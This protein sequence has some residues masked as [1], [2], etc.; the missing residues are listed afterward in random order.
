MPTRIL[1]RMTPARRNKVLVYSYTVRTYHRLFQPY[2]R[3]FIQPPDV[4]QSWCVWPRLLGSITV[5]IASS[6]ATFTVVLLRSCHCCC[7][8]CKAKAAHNGAAFVWTQSR[9]SIV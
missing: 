7:M 5:S 2:R 9:S 8:A 1:A 4:H 6:F 3:V